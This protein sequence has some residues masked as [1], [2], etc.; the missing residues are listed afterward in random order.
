[1][2]GHKWRHKRETLRETQ[3]GAKYNSD[4]TALMYFL[5]HSGERSFSSESRMHPG[6]MGV[7]I[8][9]QSENWWAAR[10]STI[11][12]HWDKWMVCLDRLCSIPTPS[13]N[14][15]G[16]KSWIVKCLFVRSR[17]RRKTGVRTVRRRVGVGLTEYAEEGN[18]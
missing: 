1:M 4:P 6:S 16:P 2:G 3:K 11:Y 18:G 12:C 9:E 5:A 13:K 15:V 14:V 8:G 17:L 10:R 7:E